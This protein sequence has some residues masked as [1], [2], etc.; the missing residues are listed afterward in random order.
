MT[1]ESATG[2]LK[3]LTEVWSTILTTAERANIV[4]L[5]SLSPPPLSLFL[6]L[7]SRTLVYTSV[8]RMIIRI[9]VGTR[10]S[11]GRQVVANLINPAR[12][13]FP[14]FDARYFLL[15]FNSI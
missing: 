5:P 4:S 14:S 7:A 15:P 11:D 1:G 6:F 13:E 12:I 2:E 9:K 8:A 10:S 3:N